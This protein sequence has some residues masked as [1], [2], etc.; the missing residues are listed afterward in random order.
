[1]EHKR[2]T[3]AANGVYGWWVP[4]D[5]PADSGREAIRRALFQVDRPVYLVSRDNSL[6]AA[7][8]GSILIGAGAAPSTEALP[9][10]AY[11]PAVHPADLGD[12]DFR[13]A[14]G[15]RYA[16]ICGAMANG[17]TSTA[18]VEAAGRA[19]M[20]GFF[21]AA[22]LAP[23]KVEAAIDT[24]DRHLPDGL[25]GCNLI[26]S[27]TDPELETA[28]VDLYLRRGVRRISASAYLRLTPQLVRYR[29]SGIHRAA[30]GAIVCPNRVKAKVSRVEVASRFFSPPPAKILA[31]L[32]EQG[33]IT[34]AQ[35]ELAARVPMADDLTAEADS[36]GH[37]DNRPALALLPTMLSLRDRMMEKH[38]YGAPLFVGLGGGIATP[39]AT[40]AAFAMGAAYVLAG[41]VHQ[42]CVESGTTDPVRRMLAE[43]RQADVVMAPAA[44]MFEMGV[45]VQVLK[46]G[47]LF[48]V[49][50]SKLYDL[51][52][53]Y[54]RWEQI[55]QAD[56]DM[57]E[58]DLLRD[59]FDETWRR[60]AAFF[61]ARDPHQLERA[62]NDAHH[63]LALVFRTYL[64]LSSRW[65]IEGQADRQLDFQIWCGPSM[66]AFN[67]WSAGTFLASAE[68]RDTVTVAMNLLYGA[69]VATRVHILK[70]CG[71]PLD[72]DL[73]RILPRPLVDIRSIIGEGL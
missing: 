29:I 9:L 2:A 61:A 19:G 33:R 12:A 18:M 26:H 10:I 13:A 57:I 60:T 25:Y 50:A 49:R 20:I 3:A 4:Q 46:R 47:T 23:D 71:A 28:L 31:A 7:H 34:P 69:A 41:S 67:E 14:Y 11:T 24:L 48:A 68:N 44:D 30:D 35:A 43:A 58:R 52:R 15:L 17:I 32:V 21:G 27:P 51:Y 62:E 39:Q 65:P 8:T 55:P 54:S 36:G 42:A 40:A 53:R 5:R 59:S 72:N 64:G 1:M 45:K 16:Y 56:R 22:G 38:G 73:T 37:T 63:K 6:A 66:G 70:I